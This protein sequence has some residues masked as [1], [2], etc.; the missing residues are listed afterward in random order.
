MTVDLVVPFYNP[1]AGWEVKFTDRYHRLIRDFFDGDA[2]RIHIVIVNDGSAEHFTDAEIRYIRQHIPAVDMISY[3][4]NKGKGFALRAGVAASNA[5]LC[6]CSDNDFP[7]GLQVIRDMYDMLVAGSADIITGC[8]THGNYFSH[9]PLKRR[10]ASKGLVF[11][12][13]HILGLPVT[14]TQG[15]IKAFNRKGR[16]IFLQTTMDRF[17]FDVE[18]ILLASK[19]KDTRIKEVDVNIAQ[20]VKMS[21]FS[22]KI[23]LQESRNLLRI[24]LNRKHSR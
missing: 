17:L 24:L 12:N 18:F 7:F 10:I 8:R 6:I 11:V 16:E 1:R 20:D 14:D 22:A 9:L 19:R 15:G 23:M 5:E 21:D 2:S 3:A 4:E 13:R